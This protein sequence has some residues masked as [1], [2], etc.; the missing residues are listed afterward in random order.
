MLLGEFFRRQLGVGGSGRMDSQR[1]H[2]SH[3]GKEREYLE[4]VYDLPSLGFSTFHLESENAASS[5][6]EEFC[7]K[8]MVW[9]VWQAL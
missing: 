1:L 7:V 5:I 2:V 8:L 9:M 6:G 3:I 4:A